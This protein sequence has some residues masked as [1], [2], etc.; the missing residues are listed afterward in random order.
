[1]V[2]FDR[3]MVISSERGFCTKLTTSP[4]NEA[5]PRPTHGVHSVRNHRRWCAAELARAKPHPR[6]VRAA[7]PK[8]SCFAHGSR[9]LLAGLVRDG[10]ARMATESISAGGRSVAVAR[11][12]ITD[13]GRRAI[14]PSP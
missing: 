4:K 7:A 3:G 11:L 9:G 6:R 5:L 13:A 1:M 8:R 2:A 10:L 14:R 12:R